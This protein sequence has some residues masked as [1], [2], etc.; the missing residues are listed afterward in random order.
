MK[1]NCLQGSFNSRLSQSNKPD[2]LNTGNDLVTE[3]CP[4]IDFSCLFLSKSPAVNK[5]KI[6]V[7]QLIC[8]DLLRLDFL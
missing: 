7:N 2:V 4:E 8:A 6:P 1:I 3:Q 5:I